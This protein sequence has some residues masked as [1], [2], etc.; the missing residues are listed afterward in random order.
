MRGRTYRYFND[1]LFPFG[2]GLSFTSFE[3]RNEKL[4]MKNDGSGLL[5]V[6]VTNT[7][8]R[9]GTEIVQVYVRN[10]S[11]PDAPLKTLRAFQRVELK[12][13]QTK[14]VTIELPRQSFE[15]FDTDTNTM[16]VKA[17]RYE[18]LYGSS[19]ADQDLKCLTVDLLH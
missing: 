15:F 5:S 18:V 13:G 3:M 2:Y 11:D 7:G 10:P 12:A 4:E 17:G 14:R 8:H 19:S 9:D 6:E 16:R 1:A